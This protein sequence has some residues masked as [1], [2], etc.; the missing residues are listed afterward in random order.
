MY[1][2]PYI[3]H[4]FFYFTVKKNHFRGFL[5]ERWVGRKSS[6]FGHRLGRIV[7]YNFVDVWTYVPQIDTPQPIC[8]CQVDFPLLWI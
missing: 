7:D 2:S 8:E 5:L 6:T 3:A 1:L 4:I